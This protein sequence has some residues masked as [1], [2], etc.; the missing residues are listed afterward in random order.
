MAQLQTLSNALEI[1]NILG[2]ADHF[3]SVEDIARNLELP[4]STTYRLV[5][6]L[7]AKGF[8]ERYSRKKI[9][10]GS[11][12]I[13]L[14]RTLYD[15]LDKE[16]VMVSAPYM[17]KV[18]E[19]TKETTILSVRAGLSSKCIKSVSSK[20]IIRFVAEENRLLR[21][22]IGAS[23]RAILAFEDEKIIDMVLEALE[24]PEERERLKEDLAQIRKRGYAITC[25]QYDISAVGIAVPLFNA[26]GRICAS[27]AIVGPDSRVKPEDYDNYINILIQNGKQ[28]T[29]KLQ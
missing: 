14:T 19:S 15:R 2:K 23:S 13:S 29:E 17:E 9:G 7:E 28:I 24:E 1:L 3:L 16:L 6:T 12:L 21:L 26:F 10:L 25:N 11:N 5:Q 20:Y 8:V 4:E 18:C 22:D 27:M